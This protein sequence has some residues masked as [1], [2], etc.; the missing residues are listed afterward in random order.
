VR[1]DLVLVGFGNVGRR[2]VRLLDE[3]RAQLARDHGIETRVVAI[4]T[5]T[6]GHV[7]D[8]RGLNAAALAD[9]V[10]AGSRVGRASGPTMTFLKN[11]LARCRTSARDGRLVVVETTTLAIGDGQPAIDHVK[12]ALL[13]GAHVVT[14][15]KGPAAFAFGMLTTAAERARRRFLFES[16][17]MD[18]V[19]VF[20]LRRTTL[21]ALSVKGFDGVVNST[22]NH[23]LTAM[24][25]GQSFDS[26]LAAMQHDGI[27]EADP[28]LDVDGWD[29]AA[30]AA[31]LANVLLGAKMTPHAV[32]REGITGV[33][34]ARLQAARTA[35][36]RLKLVASGAGTGSGARV[37]VRLVE[38]PE[39]NL[40]AG[41]EGGENALVLHTDHLGDVAIVQRGSGLTMT[42]FGLL[43]D[44]VTISREWSP[45]RATR[46]SP[47]TVRRDRTLSG[48]GRR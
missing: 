47:P 38:L 27:A 16:A 4:A 45:R 18:G 3:S 34:A 41:L 43:S 5:R 46:R 13:A 20:N 11:S 28:S 44:L 32:D 25:D 39:S 30:K 37:S 19:P 24:E 48:R 2:F 29:A 6:R 35:G 9:N 17:V 12:T 22:T 7:F 8:P 10:E 23:I 40:L 21:P 31:A 15:N 33:S 14:A 26:A 36:R 42:A 1:F